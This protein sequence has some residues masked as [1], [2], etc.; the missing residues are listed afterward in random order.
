MEERNSEL[1]SEDIDEDFDKAESKE[2]ND[3]MYK[4]LSFKNNKIN[5][6]FIQHY[7]HIDS[8]VSIFAKKINLRF[9]AKK[10]N[11]LDCKA[12][13]DKINSKEIRCKV[14]NIL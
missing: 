9:S 7:L 13:V 8:D 1:K 2:W 12:I 14:L 3:F 11:I 4:L 10:E 5:I 6:N